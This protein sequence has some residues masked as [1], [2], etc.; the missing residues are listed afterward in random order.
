V[1]GIIGALVYDGFIHQG[2]MARGEPPAPDIEVKG[3]VPEERPVE[4]F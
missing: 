4:E 2:L 3:E 1:G